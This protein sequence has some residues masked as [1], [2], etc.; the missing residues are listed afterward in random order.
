M[1]D[2]LR[3]HEAFK[4]GNL[5]VLRAAL[6]NPS[7]F[8]NCRGEPATTGYVLEYAIYHSPLVLIRALL[9]HGADPNYTDPAGFPSLIAALSCPA[10]PDLQDLMELL[11]EHG[12]DIQ[13][14]GI[15]DYTPLHFAAAGN[16]S[17]MIEWLLAHGADPEAK[18][19]IDEYATPL[20]E[21]E[22]LGQIEAV[23]V[24]RGYQKRPSQK[25]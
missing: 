12:A 17:K 19:H 11:V 15:N 24:L 1:S 22:M 4:Q 10:R 18:T 16:D 2:P 21:A 6:G 3:I 25:K 23:T 7:G 20:A 13:Q 9:E 14:R 8:P 5:E